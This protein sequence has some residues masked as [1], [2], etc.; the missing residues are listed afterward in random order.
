LDIRFNL[1]APYVDYFVLV[2]AAQTHTGKEKNLLFKE[3]K[4]KYEKFLSQIIYVCVDDFP[5]A[6]DPWVRENYQRNAMARGLT[7]CSDEDIILISDCDEIPNPATI[8]LLRRRGL[9][10]LTIIPM[11]MC[12]YFVNF[13]N[14]TVPL[15]WRAKACT[16]AELKKTTPNKIRMKKFPMALSKKL[17]DNG[18]VQLGWHMSYLGGRDE[19]KE[20]MGAIAHQ[21]FNTKQYTSSTHIEESIIK[22]TDIQ[23]RNYKL[24]AMDSHMLLPDYI[25]KNYRRYII[26]FDVLS[27]SDKAENT[28]LLMKLKSLSVRDIFVMHLRQIVVRIINRHRTKTKTIVRIHE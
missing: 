13:L 26:D 15:W 9:D 3:N 5:N 28:K 22:G 19:I 14:V 24:R 6:D 12:L 7:N 18:S 27:D 21:E 17:E 10:K 4:A 1:L 11:F 23:G 16:Y 8:N 2:E 20:K 25:I